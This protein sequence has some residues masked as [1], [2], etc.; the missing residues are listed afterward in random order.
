ME[1]HRLQRLEGLHRVGAGIQWQ[2]GIMLGVPVSIRGRGL[3]L[4]EVTAVGKEH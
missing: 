1:I 2:C 4:L 3:F